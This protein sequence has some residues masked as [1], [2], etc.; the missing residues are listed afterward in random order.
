MKYKNPRRRQ[1]QQWRAQAWADGQGTTACGPARR[2]RAGLGRGRLSGLGQ[3]AR[4][5]PCVRGP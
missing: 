5:A 4:C 1:S 2:A 3:G